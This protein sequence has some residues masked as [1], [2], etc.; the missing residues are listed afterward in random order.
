MAEESPDG[1][2]EFDELIGGIDDP[3][4]GAI[5]E[6]VDSSSW[7]HN[8]RQTQCVRKVARRT[9][10]QPTDLSIEER[11]KRAQKQV[12]TEL[13]LDIGTVHDHYSR[14]FDGYRD[15]NARR[16]QSWAEM[17]DEVLEAVENERTDDT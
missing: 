13:E 4:L 12:A 17:F 16:Q 2:P 7:L 14:L 5:D 15:P 6:R 8:S 11:R 9:L 1:A 3:I 10:S